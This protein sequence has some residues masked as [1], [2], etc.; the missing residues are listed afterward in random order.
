[1]TNCK[2]CGAVLQ[3]TDPSAPGYTPKEGSEYCQRCFRLM[4]YDDLTVSM[5]KGIDPDEVMHRIAGMD[6][7]I[8]WV[9]D[10]FD[11]EAGIIPGLNRML[12]DKDIILAC[13][14]RDILPDTL[15]EEKIAR[16]VF[17]RLKEQ[18]IKVKSLILTSKLHRMGVDEVK[19]AVALYAKGR[20]VVVMGKANS[21]KS[22]LL[23]NLMGTKQL[24]M[25]RYPGTTLDFNEI[26]IDGQKYIDTPGIEI[27]HSLLMDLAEEDLKD[28][29]PASSLKPM[30]FQLRG[31][32][33]F[34]VGGLVRLDLMNC[35]RASCVFYISDRLNIHRGKVENAEELW[36]KHYGELFLPIAQTKEFTHYSVHKDIDKM[37]I[38][39]DG[40]GWASISGQIS[41]VTVY[42]PKGVNVTFR[43]AML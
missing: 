14:K 4:H 28:V 15:N 18:G 20:P 31:N 39:V 13:A 22:T 16:F 43:K 24:T 7:L 8:L 11:F 9:V 12:A 27:S 29:L 19:D 41:T 6:C 10:L 26:D 42:V 32:Q 33:S 30:V 37:D 36:K 5:R 40:L 1:M 25:S 38:V 23:N 17:G 21:G 2:G 3:S 34:A 35:D